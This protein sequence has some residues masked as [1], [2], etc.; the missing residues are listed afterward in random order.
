LLLPSRTI[1]IKIDPHYSKLIDPHKCLLILTFYNKIVAWEEFIC[2]PDRKHEEI[3]LKVICYSPQSFFTFYY[4]CYYKSYNLGRIITVMAY[5]FRFLVCH[6]FIQIHRKRCWL[7]AFSRTP[8]SDIAPR[9]WFHN[10]LLLI[11]SELLLNLWNCQSITSFMWHNIK[12]IKIINNNT[13]WY[14]WLYCF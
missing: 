2:G 9:Y 10:Q 7:I 5:T 1:S 3:V 14:C 6:Y 8:D 11:N 4:L 13:Y 12:H